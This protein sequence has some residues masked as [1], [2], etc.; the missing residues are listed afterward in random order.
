MITGAITAGLTIPSI[1]QTSLILRVPV[2]VARGIAFVL[3]LAFAI[4]FAI[5]HWS[6][7]TF[8]PTQQ[9]R[10]AGTNLL[11][12][13]AAI[14]GDIYMPYHPWYPHLVG[15]RTFAHRMGMLDLGF[16]GKWPIADIGQALRQKRFG[17]VILD[18]R[19]RGIESRGL[20]QGYSLH[21]FP[22][23]ARPSLYTGAGRHHQLGG[24]ALYPN[25][26]WLPRTHDS[27]PSPKS[28]AP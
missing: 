23:D 18:N 5:A 12:Q 20:L 19:P 8:I 17:A 1:Y 21:P 4:Q 22:L 15:K 2:R 24:N 28:K 11:K 26:L 27:L 13:L 10:Q 7:H 3:V 14:D 25:Q 6:P 16:S 9:D